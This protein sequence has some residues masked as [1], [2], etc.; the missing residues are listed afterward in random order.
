MT[1]DEYR[2]QAQ[3]LFKAFSEGDGAAALRYKWEHPRFKGK[4]IADVEEARATLDLS[5]AQ[6][7]VAQ[8]QSF[9][10]WDELVAFTNDPT[11]TRFEE[12]VDAVVAGDIDK[13]RA[14]LADD[15]SLV[16]ARSKRRHHCT[17]LHY[18]G[19]NGVEGFRQK[20]PPNAVEV[21]KLLLDSGAEPNALADLYDT[22]CTT[23]SMVVTSSHPAEAGLQ[24]ALAE[25]LLDY[26]AANSEVR[27]ALTFGYV[28]TAEALARRGASIDFIAAAGLNRVDDVARLLPT[29]DA[30]ERHAALA[31][32]TMLGHV[33]VARILLDAGE[34]PSRFNPEGF[35]AHATPLHN[36]IWNDKDDVVRLLVERGARLD[37]KDKIFLGTPLDW[38]VYGKKD[39]LAEYLRSYGAP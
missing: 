22:K 2:A 4:T 3:E 6:M 10:S 20:T 38:A 29:A 11:V 31:L 8:Q 13:L 19:A 37:I 32:S 28:D 35:H 5:D 27:A 9:N 21:M 33:E 30:N 14:F 12:A 17:L 24:I 1:V 36:A 7:V 26:G 25:T 34:D 16:H 18:L 39:E 15:P 23:M